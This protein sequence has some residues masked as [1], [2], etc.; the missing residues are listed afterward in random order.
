[1][2]GTVPLIIF[3]M[4]S[5]FTVYSYGIPRY[6]EG[7]GNNPPGQASSRRRQGGQQEAYPP[8]TLSALAAPS[9]PWFPFPLA[10]ATSN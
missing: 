10:K 1:M 6:N 9:L 5:I 3:S 7:K 2:T 8:T 4:Y